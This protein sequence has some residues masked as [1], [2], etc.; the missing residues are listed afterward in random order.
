MWKFENAWEV[1]YGMEERWFSTWNALII[2]LAINGMV[3]KLLD[4]F[5]E[6]KKCCVVPN[7]ITFMGFLGIVDTWA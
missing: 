3:D 1:F 5:S 4:M 2:G 7:V 6:E